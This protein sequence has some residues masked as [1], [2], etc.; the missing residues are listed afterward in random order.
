MANYLIKDTD[1][2]AVADAI[3]SK[4]GTSGSLSFPSGFVDA[5]GAISGGGGSLPSFMTK[6]DSGVIEP[7]ENITTTQTIAHSLGEKPLV[8]VIWTDEGSWASSGDGDTSLCFALMSRNATYNSSHVGSNKCTYCFRA[9]AS[10]TAYPGPGNTIGITEW[11]NNNS[12]QYNPAGETGKL[13]A[14]RK[15]YW[16]AWA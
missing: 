14:G 15:Y 3:R 4:G 6:L 9:A 1:L 8:I 10:P 12:F 16:M 11:W 13:L 7:I 5:I 2:I